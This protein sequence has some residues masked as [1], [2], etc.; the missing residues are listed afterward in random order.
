MSFRLRRHRRALR[1][2]Q[3]KCQHGTARGPL[4]KMRPAKGL[5]VFEEVLA[6]RK[7]SM[8][9]LKGGG[10]SLGDGAGTAG[11]KKAGHV[12]STD[13]SLAVLSGRPAAVWPE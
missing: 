13:F 8:W 1:A 10:A 7:A 6:I 11:S 3:R 12:T 9:T 5:T 2:V 4:A